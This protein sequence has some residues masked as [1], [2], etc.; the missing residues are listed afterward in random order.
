MKRVFVL[1]LAL[2]FVFSLSTL[3]GFAS[4]NISEEVSVAEGASASD[5]IWAY[6]VIFALSLIAVVVI[7]VLITKKI[8]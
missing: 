4:D 3:S 5:Y 1:L 7:A 6:Y 2:I 8:K